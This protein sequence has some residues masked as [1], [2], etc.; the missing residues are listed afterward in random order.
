M[1][2]E[3]HA[4]KP[5]CF[6]YLSVFMTMWLFLL[7]IVHSWVDFPVVSQYLKQKDKKKVNNLPRVTCLTNG[8]QSI[9]LNLA[10]RW[11]MK[12]LG[13]DDITDFQVSRPQ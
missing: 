9:F 12:W 3:L 2:V 10:G 6:L 4:L 13:T 11:C 1:S 8:T 7:Y 5:R